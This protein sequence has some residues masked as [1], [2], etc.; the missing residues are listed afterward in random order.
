MAG[1][2][3]GGEHRG[4][5]RVPA[6][7]AGRASSRDV[8]KARFPRSGRS[9]APPHGGELASHPRPDRGLAQPGGEAVRGGIGGGT[10]GSTGGAGTLVGSRGADVCAGTGSRP[11]L[12]GGVL[13]PA[14]LAPAIAKGRTR[15]TLGVER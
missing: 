13:A 7:G 11:T 15:R 5:A 1:E 4:G 8:T 2:R 3:R 10:G 14:R 9:H 6:P 12:A